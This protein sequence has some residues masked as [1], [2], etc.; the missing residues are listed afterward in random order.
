[1]LEFAFGAFVSR[2]FDRDW[3]PPRGWWL[4]VAGTLLMIAPQV[5][6]MPR[7]VSYGVPAT[8]ILVGILAEERS[9]RMPRL[10]RLKL[11]GDASY[12]IYLWHL[13]V[14]ALVFRVFGVS[15]PAFALAVA[16]GVVMGLLSYRIIE[17][18]AMRLL[19][20]RSPA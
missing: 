19:A 14:V 11:L 4:V 13:F 5:T 3:L 7:F 18:P 8:L 17:R 16:G 10:R 15:P 2:M 1:M 9:A 6:V 20:S 12:S